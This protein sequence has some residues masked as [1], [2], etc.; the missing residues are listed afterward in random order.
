[1]NLNL[2]AVEDQPR[3]VVGI[4]RQSGAIAANEALQS[5]ADEHGDQVAAG[6]IAKLPAMAIADI[7]R[8][9]DYTKTGL[10]NAL[11]TPLQLRKV[12]ERLPLFEG[13]IE[14]TLCAV[15]L[16]HEEMVERGKYFREVAK[17]EIGL[18]ALAVVFSPETLLLFAR[19]GKFDEMEDEV[20]LQNV[21]VGEWQELLFS[22]RRSAPIT[23]GRVVRIVQLA[24]SSQPKR[25]LSAELNA[26]VRQVFGSTE[27]KDPYA[28]FF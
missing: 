19:T 17:S 16:Q 27:T 11:L 22:L 25:D 15:I 10:V 23:F 6:V 5:V 26:A 20:T 4:L 24:Y 7:A 21:Q 9:F 14:E 12:I 28:D 13:N 1:M 8:E 3:A 18:T 2:V